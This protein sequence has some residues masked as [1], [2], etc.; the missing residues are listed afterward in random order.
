MKLTH[1][2]D[3]TG[4]RLQIGIPGRLRIGMHGRL[5]RNPQTGEDLAF[6]DA[7]AC[8]LALALDRI[9]NQCSCLARWDN[10][11]E[12]IPRLRTDDPRCGT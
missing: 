9:A 5:R 2:K 8:Y 3:A 1:A 11:G 12:K 10:T 4:G 6:A 7:V